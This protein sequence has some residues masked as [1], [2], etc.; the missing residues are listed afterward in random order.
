MP[1]KYFVFSHNYYA[2]I[3]ALGGGIEIEGVPKID[4]KQ[5]NAGKDA[6]SALTAGVEQLG[7]L[8]DAIQK[9]KGDN[10][11]GIEILTSQY[12][13]LLNLVKTTD[14]LWMLK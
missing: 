10:S 3:G 14:I 12:K 7:K 13:Q 8:N 2:W 6:A 11:K 1:Q 5:I 9:L 4:K